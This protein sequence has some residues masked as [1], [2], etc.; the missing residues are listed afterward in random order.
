MHDICGNLL[1]LW[2]YSRKK[3]NLF[4][5]IFR[6]RILVLQ[7]LIKLF[8]WELIALLVLAVVFAVFLD[9]VVSQ[10]NSRGVVVKLVLIGGG[11]DVPALVEV[12]AQF[13]VDWAYHDVVAD[14]E[15]AAFV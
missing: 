13:A 12:A 6:R 2:M 8:I 10:V 11:S 7:I 15:F 5:I 1:N 14:V 4:S 3:S 9:S